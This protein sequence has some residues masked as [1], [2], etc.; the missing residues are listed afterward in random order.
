MNPLVKD[1]VSLNEAETE[2]ELSHTDQINIPI[3]EKDKESNGLNP[4]F[5]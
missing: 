1:K 3:A 5:F 4:L 2:N